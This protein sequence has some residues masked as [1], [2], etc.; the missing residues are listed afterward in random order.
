MKKFKCMNIGNCDNANT[1]ELFELAEGEEQ[2]CPKCGSSM[3]V[4]AGSKSWK[5][6]AIIA[7]VVAVLAGA[8]VGIWK[9]T[10][11]KGTEV[12]DT[13]SVDTSKV[14]EKKVTEEKKPIAIKQ[15][16]IKDAKDV[17]LKK[18][19]TKQLTFT[20]IPNPNDEIPT[21]ESSDSTVA[22]VGENGLVTAV[23]K[24]AAT[25]TIKAKGTS[26]TVNIT[27]TE[28]EETKATEKKDKK[29]TKSGSTAKGRLNLGYGTYT[30]DKVNGKP[31]GFGDIVFSRSKYINSS[32]TAEPG[33]KI[34]N[35][36]FTN[37]KLQSGTLY[38]ED[39]IKIGFID[40]NNNL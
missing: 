28:E 12:K 21:W 2:K 26:D 27:V 5:P 37:G 40:A 20:A 35:A 22:T 33:Y 11:G 38:D 18:G 25:I 24:G 3:L 30:G 32:Y 31:N 15:I 7:A 4:E 14:K 36:R 8:G 23:K 10:G 19:E 34:R 13:I 16:A 29:E 9:F 17:T 39:G 1:G 6:I